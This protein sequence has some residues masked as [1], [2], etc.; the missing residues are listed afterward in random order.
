MCKEKTQQEVQDEFLTAMWTAVD[1]WKGAAR[2]GR[3]PLGDAIEGVMHSMLCILDGVAGWHNMSYEIVPTP[4][5]EEEQLAK[6]AGRDWWPA[7][8]LP[9]GMITV[10]GPA[11]LHESMYTG[12][13]NHRRRD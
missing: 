7:Q 8:A 10:H 9:A 5:D 12:I 1:Y 13:F 4:S 6:D 11:M 3:V 2:R